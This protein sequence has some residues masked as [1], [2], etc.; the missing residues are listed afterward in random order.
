MSGAG[1]DSLAG[2]GRGRGLFGNSQVWVTE[3]AASTASQ[4]LSGDRRS[5]R[6]RLPDV[7]NA[8]PIE[9]NVGARRVRMAAR[10]PAEARKE[11]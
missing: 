6:W 1:G 5:E 7:V 9:I 2:R 3:S 10:L 8:R 4:R 11:S